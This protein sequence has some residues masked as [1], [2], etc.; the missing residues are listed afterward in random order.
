MLKD[1]TAHLKNS[2]AHWLRNTALKAKT[3]T[4]TLSE[5][6]V[7]NKIHRLL[8]SFGYHFESGPK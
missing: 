7:L 5:G 4:K 8:L 6:R 2:T 3:V 1:L